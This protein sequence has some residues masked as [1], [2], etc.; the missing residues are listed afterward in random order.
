MRLRRGCEGVHKLEA[1]RAQFRRASRSDVLRRCVRTWCE[2]RSGLVGPPSPRDN[3]SLGDDGARWRFCRF[4]LTSV[5]F[6]IARV[7]I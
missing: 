5:F 7:E 6:G 2:Q 1:S 4:S 3:R